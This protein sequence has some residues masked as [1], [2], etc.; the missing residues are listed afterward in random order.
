MITHRTIQTQPARHTHEDTKH[1]HIWMHRLPATTNTHIT[2]G[3]EHH[4]TPFTS[5]TRSSAQHAL[6]SNLGPAGSHC[7]LGRCARTSAEFEDSLGHMIWTLLSL[8]KEGSVLH[9]NT[10]WKM[11]DAR[12][13]KEVSNLSNLVPIS[14]F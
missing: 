2:H 8:K 14:V 4:H 12:K 11:Q 5:E 6:T 13:H 1:M 9:R 3:P 10:Q 7:H